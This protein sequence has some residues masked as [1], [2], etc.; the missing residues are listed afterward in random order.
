MTDIQ[1]FEI[2][3]PTKEETTLNVKCG[4]KTV[5]IDLF[6]WDVLSQE[7]RAK[8]QALGQN[9]RDTFIDVMVLSIEE[10]YGISLG[11]RAL[12]GL[13]GKIDE[14]KSNV[15]KKYGSESE[16][17]ESSEQPQDSESQPEVLPETTQ[18]N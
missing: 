13:L 7:V 14:M 11:K 6:D 4:G 16:S 17:V 10:K 3:L 5:S 9:D 15:K 12:A 2:E 8:T 18:N 1:I